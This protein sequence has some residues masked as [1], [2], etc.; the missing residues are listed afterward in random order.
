MDR[1]EFIR[2]SALGLTGLILA[3]NTAAWTLPKE[4]FEGKILTVTG[5]IE[6]DDLGHCLTHEHLFSTFGGPPTDNP[7]YDVDHINREV[8]PYLSYIK[9]LGIDS[10]VDSTCCFF[11]RDPALLHSLS[12]KSGLYI[13]TNTGYYGA[14][15]DQYV[16]KSAY[17]M[18]S[19]QIAQI[20]I[21]EFKNGID[22][23][24]IKPGY[25]KTAVDEGPL[26][27]IDKKLV[28]A[29]CITHLET[30]LTMAV[31]TGDNIEAAKQEFAILKDYGVNLEA[32]IWI[33]AQDVN[34]ADF[35]LD[36]ASKGAWISFDGLGIMRYD[37]NKK[38][39]TGSNTLLNHFN[40][41]KLFKEHGLLDKVLLSH[42]GDSYPLPA[43]D[44]RPYDVLVQEF[45]PMLFA[46][47]FTLDK[48]DTMTMDN[49]AKALTIGVR[50]NV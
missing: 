12:V 31:H 4:S 27:D 43:D 24:D 9:K 8:L 22:P 44:K 39:Y 36:V 7:Q 30:G 21:N 34:D 48:V 1:K 18:S 38:T 6:P 25:I 37:P 47:G 50:K 40:K 42:D 20:W 5:P 19:R 29:A 13:L 32:W 26:S 33:H 14:A 45:I 16:P 28:E 23:T 41:V 35:L 49:P 3:H 15:H 2:Q 46:A 17:S 11:G 10:I